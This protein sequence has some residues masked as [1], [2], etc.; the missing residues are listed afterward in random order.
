APA[1]IDQRDLDAGAAAVDLPQHGLEAETVTADVRLGPDL[2]INRD[3]VALAARLH[4]KAG[5][6]YQRDRARLDLAIQALESA[7]HLLAGQVL[8]DIDIETVALELFGDVARIV[9]RLLQRRLGV[10]IF[11]VADDQCIALTGCERRRYRRD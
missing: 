7:V 2:G 8:A 9:D 10:R 6:E 1:S 4:A 11:R 5:E 3:H